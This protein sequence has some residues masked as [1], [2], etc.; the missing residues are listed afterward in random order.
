M[1]AAFSQ[2]EVSTRSTKNSKYLDK[3]VIQK[4]GGPDN[5]IDDS[6]IDYIRCRFVSVEYPGTKSE[7]WIFAD[8]NNK[9][10]PIF[11]RNE[12]AIEV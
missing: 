4:I 6:G 3:K 5:L 9:L 1:I 2:K 8:V 11:G 12:F 7:Q 10:F